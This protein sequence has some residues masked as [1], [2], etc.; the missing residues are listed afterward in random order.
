MISELSPCLPI[1]E[2]LQAKAPIPFFNLCSGF[3]RVRGTGTEEKHLIR[4]QPETQ[5]CR[6]QIKVFLLTG[7]RAF[8]IATADINKHMAAEGSYFCNLWEYA[9]AFE[10]TR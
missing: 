9:R 6:G 4:C 7:Q 3:Q 2:Q 10:L 8:Q 1:D 5:A